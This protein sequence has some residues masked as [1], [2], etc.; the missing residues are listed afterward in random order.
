[1]LLSDHISRQSFIPSV[2]SFK[3]CHM[4]PRPVTDTIMGQ[5]YSQPLV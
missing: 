4:C 3:A 2:L 5:E 1:M